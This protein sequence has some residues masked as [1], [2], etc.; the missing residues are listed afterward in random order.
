MTSDNAQ[1]LRLVEDSLAF[2]WD[3]G[4]CTPVNPPHSTGWRILPSLMTAHMV[5]GNSLLETDDDTQTLQ[6]DE[7]YCLPAELHHRLTLDP[8]TSGVSRWS[9]TRFTLFGGLDA[10]R[11]LAPQPILRGPGARAIGDMNAQLAEL[12]HG[13]VNDLRTISRR[14]ALGFSLLALIAEQSPLRPA[15]LEL[16]RGAQRLAPVLAAVDAG[17]GEE[18]FDLASLAKIAGLSPSRFHAV[19]RAALGMAPSRWLQQRR[20]ARARELLLGSDLPV[21][22]VATRAGFGD[23]FHFSR[24]FKRVHGSSPLAYRTQPRGF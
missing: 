14:K 2:A 4:D 16:L 9:H 7:T 22:E 12:A 18:E 13:G 21:Q 1:F 15:G 5:G 11:V 24:L 17:L 6:A 20:L 8:R 23:P 3:A 19:F 10:L